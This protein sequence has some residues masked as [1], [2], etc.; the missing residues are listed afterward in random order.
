MCYR[1]TKVVH[2]DTFQVCY[3]MSRSGYTEHG[4]CV[5]G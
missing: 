1:F 4:M 3:R 5:T 2:T